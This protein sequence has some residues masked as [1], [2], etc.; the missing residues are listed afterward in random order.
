LHG[1]I[2]IRILTCGAWKICNALLENV[3]SRAGFFRQFNE[4]LHAPVTSC[5]RED[6]ICLRHDQRLDRICTASGSN[7]ELGKQVA[8][9][10][11]G[12]RIAKKPR[13]AL[14][15]K[16][17]LN[18]KRLSNYKL[19]EVDLCCFEQLEFATRLK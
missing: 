10:I 1:A 4:L 9:Y 6:R 12:S 11:T 17:L 16:K 3:T 13:A 18:L 14:Q 5:C 8:L 19:S 15:W 7:Q 2:H